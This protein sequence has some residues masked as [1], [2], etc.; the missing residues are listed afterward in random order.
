MTGGSLLTSMPRNLAFVL[1]GG[2]ARGALQVGA[3]R[4]LLESGYQPDLL[5]GT[6]IGAVN[7]SF[8]AV[9]GVRL[10]SI[11]ALEQAWR[12]AAKA[13]LLTANYLRLALR[14]L[15]YRH[16]S[17]TYQQMRQFYLQNGLTEDL[18]FGDIL[19]VKLVLIASDLNHGCPVLFGEDPQQIILD[20]LLAST[21]LPPWILPMES[22]GRLLVD[23]AVSSA[24]PVE[25][26]LSLGASEIIALDLIDARGLPTESSPMAATFSKLIYSVEQRNATL[27]I[28]LAEA[29]HVPVRHI[30]LNWDAHISFWDFEHAD[31]LIEHGYQIARQAIAGWPQPKRS[32]WSR[33]KSTST[34]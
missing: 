8:L 30:R 5:V 27:E 6:S 12:D 10:E 26:A 15:L 25:P 7:A 32:W 28:A 23:G 34:T 31:S 2:G 20:G 18:R 4:A 14:S 17:G 13:Q 11:A 3:L 16:S 22:E 29:R 1:G 24:L 21:A 9:Q 19:G 33:W